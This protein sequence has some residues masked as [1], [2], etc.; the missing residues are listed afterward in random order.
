[1][2]R[3]G[4]EASP[5]SSLPPSRRSGAVKRK[6]ARTHTREYIHSGSLRR[7][8]TAPEADQSSGCLSG[9][10]DARVLGSSGS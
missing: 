4:R 6:H 1:M 3:G 7:A 5:R 9:L 10:L 2:K 8:R